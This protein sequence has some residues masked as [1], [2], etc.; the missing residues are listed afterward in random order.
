MIPN[1]INKSADFMNQVLL[2]IYRNCYESMEINNFES[3]VH[4]QR[5]IR[6]K[7]NGCYDKMY[8]QATTLLDGNSGESMNLRKYSSF[9]DKFGAHDLI[10]AEASAVIL[11]NQ[12]LKLKPDVELIRNK[13]AS[14]FDSN[15]QV[16]DWKVNELEFYDDYL[17]KYVVLQQ[18]IEDM[19]TN[20]T[21]TIIRLKTCF[22]VVTN[23]EM[24]NKRKERRQL[25]NAK[26]DKKAKVED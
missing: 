12:I 14:L 9:S 10:R 6:S 18:K 11:D 21:N 15:Y 24:E 23:N 20:V 13:R 16:K 19:L 5:V 22:P 8:V 3:Y 26:K 2:D 1:P 7:I 4:T 17:K 25:E